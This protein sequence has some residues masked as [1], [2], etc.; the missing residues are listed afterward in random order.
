MLEPRGPKGQ[1]RLERSSFGGEGLV[2]PSDR[3]LFFCGEGH[4]DLGAVHSDDPY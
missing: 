4:S 3:C 1:V 2:E